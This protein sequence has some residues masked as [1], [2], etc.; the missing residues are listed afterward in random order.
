[1]PK[2]T[3]PSKPTPEPRPE[4]FEVDTDDLIIRDKDGKIIK[5]KQND[6]SSDAG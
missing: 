1:M 2:T 6:P 4:R 5:P 3:P